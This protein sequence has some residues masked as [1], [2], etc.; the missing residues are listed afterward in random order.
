MDDQRD[1]RI[2]LRFDQSNKNCGDCLGIV[3]FFLQLFHHA[4]T[5]TNCNFRGEK[6]LQFAKSLLTDSIFTP[7]QYI[8][9]LSLEQETVL[10][11]AIFSE[12]QYSFK[13]IYVLLC[14]DFLHSTEV[15]QSNNIIQQGNSTN[16]SKNPIIS[17]QTVTV[18][19]GAKSIQSHS[20]NPLKVEEVD[21]FSI[22]LSQK[23]YQKPLKN[24]YKWSN[25]CFTLQTWVSK[26]C[27]Y[28]YLGLCNVKTLIFCF[29]KAN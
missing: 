19:I 26:N 10:I 22:N 6:N 18:Q 21:G 11:C 8:K 25:Q 14:V 23:N 28:N 5:W 4:L 1:G 9:Y 3:T 27:F 16:P 17:Y 15:L 2:Q 20:A 24:I 7:Q 13:Y 12:I 29:R